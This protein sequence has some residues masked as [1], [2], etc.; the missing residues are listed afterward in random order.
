MNNIDK[1]LANRAKIEVFIQS[2]RIAKSIVGRGI[3][4]D[5]EDFVR[6]LNTSGA[7]MLWEVDLTGM[8]SKRLFKKSVAILRNLMGDFTLREILSESDARHIE[9][10]ALLG[11]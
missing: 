9:N 11:Y 4:S 1:V 3:D 8:R 7:I 2:I 6:V 5:N 10:V